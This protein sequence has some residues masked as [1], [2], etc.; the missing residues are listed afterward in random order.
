MITEPMAVLA[1][2]VG[3]LAALFALGQQPVGKRI[4]KAVPL[5]VFAYFVPTS[6][7]NLGVIPLESPL[8]EFIK[9][10][11]LPA[12]LVL[13]TLSVDIPG[14]LRLGPKVLILFLAATATIV[15]GG[16]LAYLL[17]SPLIPDEMTKDACKGLAA[18]SGSWIGGGANFVAIG[19]SVG[20]SSS[21]IAMMVV[22]DVAVANVWMAVLLWFS[23]RD[24]RMDATIGADRRS[25]EDL[26]R[27]IEK[28]QQATA[29]MPTLAD[30]LL[31]LF[32]CFS[33]V[34]VA[35]WYAPLLDQYYGALL[36]QL[37]SIIVEFTWVV[38]LVT[39]LGVGLSFTRLRKLEGAGASRVGSV[40]LYLLVASI[41]AGA[42]FRKVLDVPVL[43]L[44]GAVWMTFHAVILLLLRRLLKAPI[45]Y[46]A[47]GSQAN[48]GG[49]A[50]A[51]IVANAF[52]P[53]LTS[54]GVLL[55]VAGYVIGTVAGLICA[56]L[57]QLAAQIS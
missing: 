56:A 12:S 50:S 53:S 28:Y 40:M 43:L 11:L 29:T 10:W 22:V 55:A 24:E 17:C 35:Q 30:Y 14:I 1:I 49:A 39:A 52:H 51:P 16:P 46:M 20:A 3:V 47:V 23:G 42:E 4:F 6:L 44:V 7:S 34:A 33:A 48:V 13:L 19:E 8:Y 31:M 18:L 26:R 2:L 21:I 37:R 25:L 9:Q 41:G 36:P 45:F 15:L 5:L 27:K 32:L 38:L 54:V 57:L